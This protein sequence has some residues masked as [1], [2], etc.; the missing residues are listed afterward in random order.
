VAAN[1]A[2]HGHYISD[3]TQMM[4]QDWSANS[5]LS[6]HEATIAV[7]L[8]RDSFEGWDAMLDPCLGLGRRA[9]IESA[10]KEMVRIDPRNP[11]AYS[12]YAFTFISQWGGTAAEREKVLDMADKALGKGSPDACLVRGWTMLSSVG[13]DA[14][15]PEILRLANEAIRKSRCPNSSALSLKCRGLMGLK[16]RD[17]MLQVAEEGY[18][19]WPT[20]EWRALLAKGYQFRW[21]DRH[22]VAALDRAAELLATYV[23]EVPFDSNGH[24]EYGWCLSHQ[25]KRDEARKEFLTALKLDPENKLAKEKLQ[26]VR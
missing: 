11:R 8:D 14:D 7:A 25:G 12:R 22:D 13:H 18:R 17:E 23:R 1:N 3:M 10:F 9:D 4:A 15:R 26:Y 2:R 19:A 21:E 6:L 24:I 20:L 16:R 5:I